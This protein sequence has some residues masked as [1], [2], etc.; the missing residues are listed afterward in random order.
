MI[1]S[2]D[3]PPSAP[4]GS[5][6]DA[7]LA[8]ESAVPTSTLGRL[9]RGGK[10]ALGVGSA[11]A[12][13]RRGGTLDSAAISALVGEF[14]EL[15]GVAMK[16]GQMLGYLDESIPVELRSAL[17]VL[18]TAAPRSSPAEV[19]AVIR[20]ALGADADALL[21]GMEPEPFAVASIGQVHRARLPDGREV[22]IKV[23]HPGIDAAIKADFRAAAVG[24]TFGAVIGGAAVP[25]MIDEAR[26]AFEEECDFSL[27]ADRQRRFAALFAD[28]PE[29]VVPA[30]IPE[31]SR[32]ELLVT[33]WTPGRAF[34]ELLAADPPQ[35]ERDRI[36]AALFRVWMRAFYRDG[37]FHADPHPGN[38]ALQ[39][40]GRLILYDFG[41]VREVA[42]AL[43]RGFAALAAAARADDPAA[44][45]AAIT[46]VGGKAPTKPAGLADLRR[47]VRGFFGPL[48][49]PG[50][51]RIAA[52]EGFEAR[53]VIHDKRFII[54]LGLPPRFLFL[55]RLRFGLYAVLARLGACV[56]WA[57]LEGAWAGEVG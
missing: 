55:F 22:V 3:D 28:D 37:L 9:W 26:Q 50:A 53:S 6:R 51:R 43:R 36:G 48:V 39:A 56:D 5:L 12:R 2:P 49:T 14:G 4:A 7:L 18:Q 30:V 46:M 27:E 19:E 57:G 21:A 1:A 38:F 54:G 23:R 33:A 44:I 13:L 20:R 11:L 8:R 42:P 40:D 35:A 32:P 34:D 29:I 47:L 31:W 24:S 45:A 25:A 15:K 41:C 17:A 10:S 52:D 16:V